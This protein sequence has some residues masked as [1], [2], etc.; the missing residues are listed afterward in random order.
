MRKFVIYALNGDANCF[1]H[2]LLTVLDMDSKGYEVRLVIEGS[3]ICLTKNPDEHGVLFANLFQTVKDRGLIDETRLT[4]AVG[5]G[6]EGSMEVSGTP[7]MA[8]YLKDGYQ[9]ITF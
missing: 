9:V 4:C 6:A 5:V 8:D 1:L 7:G 3:A 2:V